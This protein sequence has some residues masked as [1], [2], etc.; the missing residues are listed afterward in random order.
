MHEST[1]WTSYVIGI[2]KKEKVLA[3]MTVAT[4]KLDVD[5]A[6]MRQA[7]LAFAQQTG[8][9]TAELERVF[10]SDTLIFAID[11]YLPL[12]EQHLEEAGFRRQN[13]EKGRPRRIPQELW[14]RLG[15]LADEKY[16]TTRITL[17][18]A[19]L[20]LLAKEIPPTD[21]TPT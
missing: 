3:R 11:R 8:R 13:P 19:A 10:F 2:P 16:D 21:S 1:Q 15:K 9:P 5:E 17:V 18:R 6:V 14:D 12:I 4:P 20:A 7:K